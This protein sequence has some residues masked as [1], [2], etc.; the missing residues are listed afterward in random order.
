MHQTNLVGGNV[1]KPLN[2][3]VLLDAFQQDVRAEHIVLRKVVRVAKTQIHMRVRSEVEYGV[4]V[5][6]LQTL[7]HVARDCHVPVEEAEIAQLSRLKHA[8]IVERAAIVELVKGHDVVVSLI[9]DR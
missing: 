5:V 3:A 1:V 2:L 8:R 4:D 9:F 7:D 6:L